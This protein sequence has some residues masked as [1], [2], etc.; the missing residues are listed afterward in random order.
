MYICPDCGNEVEENADIC[1]N[2][3]CPIQFIKNDPIN[4]STQE[5]MFVCP[6]CGAAVSSTSDCCLTCGCPIDYVKN[7]QIKE[8]KY[9]ARTEMDDLLSGVNEG[10][11]D[12]MYWLG[13]CYYYGENGLEEDETKAK[14]LLLKAIHK[15][16]Q[17]A[18]EDYE[19][20]FHEETPV[21][22]E[23]E[24]KENIKYPLKKLLD[25]YDSLIILDT[26]TT[27]L[28]SRENRI[29]E[30]AAI[31]VVSSNSQLRISNRLDVLIKLPYGTKL[32]GKIIE[33][34]GITDEDL[35]TKG[36]ESK[37][38]FNQFV[39]M[40]KNEKILM[41]AY[42]AHFDLSFIYHSLVREGY[43]SVLKQIN[44]LDALTIY[45]DRRSYPHKLMNAID[46]YNLNN[47]VANSH[48]AIDDTMA[49]YEVL[50]AMDEECDDLDKYINLFGYN[51]K[52]G[53]NGP[54]IRSVTY[55][56]Q[57]YNS[58]KKLYE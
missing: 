15:G 6:E 20:W 8:Q 24:T 57:P 9:T 35:R 56:P 58:Y 39:N 44:M 37:E 22:K 12:A 50:K 5:E 16:H 29:I 1:S 14:H 4:V 51:P 13:Y 46:A 54:K 23:R 48:R 25:K 11:P 34:T 17:K 53:V 49:L 38:A 18:K 28:D 36:E 42:N 41:I 43:E 27:G 47:K 52:Y 26:E 33:L 31:K 19:N 55:L 21:E 40:F 2:C 32:D 45:K 30:I 3:G 7:G 10:N